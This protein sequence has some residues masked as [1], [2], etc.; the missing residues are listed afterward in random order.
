MEFKK[1][2]GTHENGEPFYVYPWWIGFRCWLA[3]IVTGSD[4]IAIGLKIY[5][6][7]D[8][9]PGTNQVI[10]SDCEIFPPKENL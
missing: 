2:V 3:K 8:F 7:L 9:P 1:L 5:G 6:E 4:S 10:I